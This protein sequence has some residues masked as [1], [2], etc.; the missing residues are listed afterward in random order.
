MIIMTNVDSVLPVTHGF[1]NYHFGDKETCC[2]VYRYAW[3]HT[4]GT[5]QGCHAHEDHL[6]H[7]DCGGAH[8]QLGL[9]WLGAL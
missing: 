6:V 9:A 4:T 7:S 8:L 5:H 2:V 3:S 1:I